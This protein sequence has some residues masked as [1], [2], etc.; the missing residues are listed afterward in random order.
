VAQKTIGGLD[1]ATTPL[2]GTEKVEIEQSAASKRATVVEIT[3][4]I[5]PA[6][7]ILPF[8]NTSAPSGYLACDGAAVSRTTYATLFAAIGTVWGVG[9]G[10][11]TF[12]IPDLRGAFVR[13]TGSHGTANMADGNDFAGPSVGATEND[14]IQGHEHEVE[15][16]VDGSG[17][18]LGASL[19]TGSRY[20]PGY[21]RNTQATVADGTNGTPRTG[22]ETR[23]FAAGVLYCI[24]T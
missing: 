16:I 18:V 3:Q 11:T 2:D 14:Q 23:P 20:T 24:K 8:G 12:N 21:Q 19:D 5:L 7:M 1:A 6:G 4:I 9:D 17:A 10:S 22:D 15:I 13:G